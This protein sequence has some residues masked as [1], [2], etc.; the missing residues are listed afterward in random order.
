VE[1]GRRSDIAGEPLFGALLG[2][3]AGS[4]GVAVVEVPT[5]APGTFET[6]R[7]TYVSPST[8][9]II[10]QPLTILLGALTGPGVQFNFDAVRLFAA[11]LAGGGP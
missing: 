9:V 4:T 5:P 10:G 3:A 11:P 7:L 8:G 6:A 2:L 1:V